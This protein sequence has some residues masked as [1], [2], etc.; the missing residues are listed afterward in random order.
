V[1]KP[2]WAFA[3]VGLLGI[4]GVAGVL[5][6]STDGEEE[7]VQQVQETVTTSPAASPSSTVNP[8]PDA[9]ASPGT[10]S[11]G[12]APPACPPL[13]PESKPY[14]SPSLNTR[15]YEDRAAG[16]SLSYSDDWTVCLLPFDPETRDSV[17]GIAF[18][19]QNGLRHGSVYVFRNPSGLSLEDWIMDHNPI[20]FDQPPQDRTIAGM[21]A[22]FSDKSLGLPVAH[23]YIA[24]GDLVFEI[25]GL[26]QAEFEQLV[27]LFRFS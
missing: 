20:F 5:I 17:S 7:V 16:Y 24:R 25:G 22:L 26:T 21:P 3:G 8:T 4:V 19:D 12:A 10:D 14:I 1:V 18:L 13:E 15:S 9:S 2:I 27:S 11:L 6:A 23:A